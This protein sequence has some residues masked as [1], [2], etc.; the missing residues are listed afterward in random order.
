VEKSWNQKRQ[1]KVVHRL[2]MTGKLPRTHGEDDGQEE[3]SRSDADDLALGKN[4]SRLTRY[5]VWRE[6]IGMQSG[7]RRSWSTEELMDAGNVWISVARRRAMAIKRRSR[8]TSSDI[9]TRIFLT[10]HGFLDSAIIGG[11]K[12][13]GH[14]SREALVV[15]KR[16]LVEH[17]LLIRSTEHAVTE[18]GTILGKLL[19]NSR[20]VWFKSGGI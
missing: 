10:L 6:K 17:V 12:T 16:A 11:A 20:H 8:G 1:R 2:K 5:K 18:L 4:W 19:N 3:G 15:E 9:V 7:R 14:S 13:N